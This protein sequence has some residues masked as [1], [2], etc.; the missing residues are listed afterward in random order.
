MMEEVQT[1]NG[2]RRGEEEVDIALKKHLGMGK[3]E[4]E[5]KER[6]RKVKSGPT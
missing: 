3:E 2:R 5:G 4:E 6:S 1:W